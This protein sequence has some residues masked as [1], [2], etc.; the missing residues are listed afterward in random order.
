M[1]HA[2]RHTCMFFPLRGQF[3]E[4]EEEAEI[5]E[6][7]LRSRELVRMRLSIHQGSEI[8]A[9]YLK[10]NRAKGTLL[11]LHGNRPISA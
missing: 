11:Y 5:Y 8:I 6:L 9:V 4:L 7:K 3:I 2:R 10:N 1:N